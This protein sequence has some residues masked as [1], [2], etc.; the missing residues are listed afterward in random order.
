MASDGT[1]KIGD[2][3]F[4]RQA[5]WQGGAYGTLSAWRAGSGGCR[6]LGKWSAFA[7]V[8]ANHGQA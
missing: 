2:V 5:G 8:H 6:A 7:A 3:G 1:A 4:A